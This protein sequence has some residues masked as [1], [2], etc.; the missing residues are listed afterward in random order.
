MQR[1][2]NIRRKAYIAKTLAKHG[3]GILVIQL[4]LGKLVPFHWGIMGHPRRKEPYSAAEHLR[5]AFEELGATFIKLGQILSTRPDLLPEEYIQELS[6]LQDKIPPCPFSEIKRQIENELGERLENIFL[7]FE[8]TPIASASIG[9]VHKAV[10]KDGRKVAVKVQKPGVEKQIREDLEIIGE[11][12][13]QV[14]GRVEIARRIDIASFY[15]EFSYIIRGELDYIREARNAETFRENF[16]EDGDVYIPEVYWEFTTR[17][18]LTME[19]VEGIKID[20]VE[21][22]KKRG[23]SLRSIAGKGVDIFMR[24]IFRDGFFHGDPH[25]GNFFVREDG[26]IAL[27]DFGMVGIIDK[28]TRLNLLQL[29]NG[30]VKRDSSLMMDALLDLGVVGFTG[31]EY[32]LKKELEILFS[33]YT[34]L[35]IKEIRIS[36]VINEIFRL[37]YKYNI[38]LPSDLFLLMKT[39][40]MAEGLG[41]KLDPDFRVIDVMGPYVDKY[42]RLVISPSF[43]KDEVERNMFLLIKSLMESV[44]RLRRMMKRIETGKLEMSI[45]YEGETRFIEDLRKDLNRLSISILTLGFMIASSLIISAYRPELVKEE[46]VI[47]FVSALTLLFFVTVILKIWRSGG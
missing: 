17:K 14:S 23:Y 11:I 20:D 33:Y 5:M 44:E 42:R 38:K 29:I 31:K 10:L 24:M 1:P 39:I 40:A 7:E 8:E 36:E 15:D 45:K 3:F 46:F 4:G 26:S 19:Y 2:K 27:L 30:V 21:E 12:V 28:V 16:K 25:P 13:E 47:Y 9:Q 6:K 18:V 34:S 35:S 32:L 37:S 43:I 22:L 41:S